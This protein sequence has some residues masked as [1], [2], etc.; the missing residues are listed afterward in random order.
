MLMMPKARW[1]IISY[2]NLV[3]DS[4]SLNSPAPELLIIIITSQTS[5][6]SPQNRHAAATSTA[7]SALKPLQSKHVLPYLVVVLRRAL[8]PKEGRAP[9]LQPQQRHTKPPSS[10]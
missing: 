4:H 6:A 9:S 7:A 5:Q 10:I 2:T 3:F 1:L 8:P